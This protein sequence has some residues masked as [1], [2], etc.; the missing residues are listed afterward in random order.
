MRIENAKNKAS[1]LRN[2]N[3][4]TYYVSVAGDEVFIGTASQMKEIHKRL[5]KKL[6][7]VWD[8]KQNIVFACHFDTKTAHKKQ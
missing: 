1:T 4:K 3:K 8:W 7:I 5:I 6:G 2:I